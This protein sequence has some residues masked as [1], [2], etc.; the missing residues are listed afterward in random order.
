LVGAFAVAARPPLDHALARLSLLDAYRD[1]LFW[2]FPVVTQIVSMVAFVAFAA[3]LTYL[4]W[5][6]PEAL[7]RYRIQTRKPRAQELLLPSIGRWLVNNVVMFVVTLLAWPLLRL[8]GV[9]AGPLPPW[10]RVLLE[11]LAFIVLDDFLFYWMHRT[12]HHRLLFKHVHAIH[13]KILTPWAVTGHYM[14]PLEYV[15]TGSLALAGPMLF[16]SHVL[17]VWIWIAF[18]QWEAAEGH[19]GYDLPWSPT[20]LLPGSDGARHHDFHHAKVKGNYAGFFPWC[21]RVFGT[22]ARGYAEDLAAR[23]RR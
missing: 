17:T 5:R 13:H 1:P 6:D 12:L 8:S 11:V 2:S 19:A 9:H 23:R 10:W 3:P 14:H 18:R 16:S 4:A 15:L 7:R 22:Y 20:H 21:D